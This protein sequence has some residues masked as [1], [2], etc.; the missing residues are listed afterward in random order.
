MRK[1]IINLFLLVS[2]FF[3][4]QGFAKELKIHVNGMVCSFCGQGISKKF[5]EREEVEKIDVSLKDKVV[6]ITTKEGKDL[7]DEEIKSILKD[8]GYTVEK[9]ERN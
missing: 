3:T 6:T 4:I 1:F 8:A 7:K 5:N 2:L 9:I